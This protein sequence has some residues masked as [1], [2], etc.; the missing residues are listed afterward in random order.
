MREMATSAALAHVPTARLVPLAQR[1]GRDHAS[2]ST[3]HGLVRAR[4]WRRPRLRVYP[5]KPTEGRAARPSRQGAPPIGRATGE[6]AS[7]VVYD[8]DVVAPAPAR[9]RADSLDGSRL[10]AHRARR[11]SDASRATLAAG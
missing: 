3:R 1:M 9:P 7:P 4:G 10:L 2:T 6:R 8:G 5:P 11:T